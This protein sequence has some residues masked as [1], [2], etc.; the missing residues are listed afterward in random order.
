MNRD[1]A[2]AV[3][4]RAGGR[5]EYCRLPQFAFPLRFQIDH[6]VAEQHHGE[7][8]PENLALACPHCNRYK[9]PNLAGRDPVSGAVVRL[10]HPR[11]D[12]WTEH[13]QFEKA[14]I[15]GKTPVG[16]ATVQVLAMNA[17]EPLLLREKLAEIGASLF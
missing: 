17:A 11:T 13:F 6:I 5:C 12:R 4:E 7:T 3:R 1:L 16:R 10:F 15:A 14:R 2:R 9:G 8:V